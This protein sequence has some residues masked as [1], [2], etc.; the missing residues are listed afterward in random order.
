MENLELSLLSFFENPYVFLRKPGLRFKTFIE[1]IIKVYPGPG[2][3]GIENPFKFSDSPP[4]SDIEIDEEEE[5][6]QL[7]ISDDEEERHLIINFEKFAQS[8][9]KCLYLWKCSSWFTENKYKTKS[10][11]HY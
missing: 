7:D 6:E 2:K 5:E 10:W 1:D 4:E 3:E 9:F 11:Q 8:I